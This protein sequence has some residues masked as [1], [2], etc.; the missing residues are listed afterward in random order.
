MGWD[1][2]RGG[3]T[4]V[5]DSLLGVAAAGLLP[6]SPIMRCWGQVTVQ[7]RCVTY[8][9]MATRGVASPLWVLVFVYIGDTREAQGL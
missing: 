8:A 2:L 6:S 4:D 7:Q 3:D 1:K 9:R 5:P